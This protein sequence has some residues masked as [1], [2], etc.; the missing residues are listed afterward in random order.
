MLYRKVKITAMKSNY[1]RQYMLKLGLFSAGALLC[2]IPLLSL[3]TVVS[4][5]TRPQTVQ[6]AALNDCVNDIL[7]GFS[8]ETTNYYRVL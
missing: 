2:L 4:A 3:P 5:S 1:N 6:I 8:V 7:E